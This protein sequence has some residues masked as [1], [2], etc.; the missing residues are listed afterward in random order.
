MNSNRAFGILRQ[1]FDRTLSAQDD[2]RVRLWLLSDRDK[3]AK[4]EA[5]K[6]IWQQAG[7][8]APNGEEAAAYEAFLQ[9]REQYENRRSNKARFLKII[10]YAAVI[11]LPVMAA[12]MVWYASDAYH[13]GI[14]RMQVCEVPDGTIRQITLNDG[15]EIT[16]NGGS[17]I[18]YPEKFAA[19]DS[20]N[21]FISGEAFFNVTRDTLRP[22]LVHVDNMSIRVLG[23][24]FNVRAY[25]DE[26]FI[27]TTL[28]KGS[29]QLSIDDTV[30]VLRPNEQAFYTRSNRNIRK[31][32]VQAKEYTLWTDGSL[33]FEQQP[34]SR[35]IAVLSH[36]FGVRFEIDASIDTEEQFTMNFTNQ[37]NL[38]DVL[39]VM[40][41]LKKDMRYRQV[42]RT[43]IIY[44][45]KRR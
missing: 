30:I 28:Q 9:H 41:R 3:E 18:I 45:E 6:R 13:E 29:V 8:I 5:L 38:G 42:N 11:A 17:K 4:E 23:T 7:D 21:V 19:R 16:L 40:T 43:I 26:R 32:A 34:L 15:T 22:F 27:A 2:R 31:F 37:E 24:T 20:R 35:I 44:K 33:Q 14:G 1:Y 39:D 25:A 36:K 12:V 10:R